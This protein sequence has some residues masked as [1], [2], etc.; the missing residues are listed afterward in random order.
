[1]KRVEGGSGAIA[2]LGVG[3]GMAY[4]LLTDGIGESSGVGSPVEC[5]VNFWHLR[6]KP[7]SSGMVIRFWGSHSNIRLRIESN[8]EERGKIDLRN[9]ESFKYVLNVE[10]E[11][12]ALFHGL[13]PHVRLTSMTP[14]DQMSL[15][16][17]AYPEKFRGEVC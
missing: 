9:L 7:L 1:V 10:S 5:V 6:I 8:S 16:P 2:T 12:E 4:K 14:R 13:R 15:G 11:V 17:E 3:C